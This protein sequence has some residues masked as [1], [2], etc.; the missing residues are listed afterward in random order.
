MSTLLPAVS[1]TNRRLR[2][3]CVPFVS[4]EHVASAVP[5][6]LGECLLASLE[7]LAHG[8]LHRPRRE[9][10]IRAGGICQ[11]DRSGIV[12][13]FGMVHS[14]VRLLVS[15]LRWPCRPVRSPEGCKRLAG[16]VSPR[17]DVPKSLRAPKGRKSFHNNALQHSSFAPSGL[18]FRQTTFRGL[19]LPANGWPGLRPSR[20]AKPLRCSSRSLPQNTGGLNHARGDQRNVRRSGVRSF[21][22][23]PY[24]FAKKNLRGSW[25][26]PCQTR[27]TVV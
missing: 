3:L 17:T 20:A 11:I 2:T 8:F 25:F 22:V 26:F 10:L 19:A 23:S 4:L 7:E 16:G 21:L 12:V 18:R 13:S 15:G 9:G 24:R 14:R 6:R 1:E 5:H 27:Q